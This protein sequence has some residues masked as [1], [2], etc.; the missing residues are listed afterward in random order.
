MALTPSLL[1][2]KIL[3]KVTEG[4]RIFV[5]FLGGREKY[6]YSAIYMLAEIKV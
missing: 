5:D 4:Q 2:V 3:L 1:N 6:I